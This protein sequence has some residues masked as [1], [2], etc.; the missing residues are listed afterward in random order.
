MAVS[1][2]NMALP[3]LWEGMSVIAL[4]SANS[5]SAHCLCAKVAAMSHRVQCTLASLLPDLET[6][7]LVKLM[8]SDNQAVQAQH[9]LRNTAREHSACMVATC[10]LRVPG[11]SCQAEMQILFTVLQICS[12]CITCSPASIGHLLPLLKQLLLLWC[13]WLQWVEVRGLLSKWIACHE[14]EKRH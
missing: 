2:I 14:S 1:H 3:E 4:A 9:N 6:M 12:R 7:L 8:S 11:Y 5:M 10:T 13:L